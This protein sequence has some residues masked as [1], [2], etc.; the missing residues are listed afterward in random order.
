MRPTLLIWKLQGFCEV[1]CVTLTPF[2]PLKEMRG[3]QQTTQVTA[4]LCI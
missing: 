3:S 4:T 2:Q 1:L